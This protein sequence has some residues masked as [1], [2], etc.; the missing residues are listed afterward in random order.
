MNRQRRSI[1][2]GSLVDRSRQPP[3]PAGVDA[4]PLEAAAPADGARALYRERRCARYAR[5]F[6]LP[7]EVD[8]ARSQ[9]RLE[10]GVLT[11]TLAKKV[12]AGARRISIN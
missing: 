11:L 8:E 4:K 7:V 10:N 12:P 9:A 3:R 2:G 1:L 5:R 6:T